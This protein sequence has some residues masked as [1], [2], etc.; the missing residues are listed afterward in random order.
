MSKS[1]RRLERA[2]RLTPAAERARREPEW[3]ADVAGARQNGLEEADVTRAARSMAVRLRGRQ[4]GRVLLG[5]RGVGAAVTGWVVLLLVVVA[6]LLLGNV[7]LLLAVLVLAVAA[8]AVTTAGTPSHWSHWSM[9]ASV[10]IGVSSFAFVWWVVGVRIDAADGGTPEP[11][12]ASWDWAGLV[13]LALAA[14]GFVTS[15]AFALRR[16]QSRRR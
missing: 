13:G 16:E 6:A 10:L 2:V 9:V 14:A 3:R 1:E 7:F 4:I 5:A 8:V 11:P 12:L 15:A